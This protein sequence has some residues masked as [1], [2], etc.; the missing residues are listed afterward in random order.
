M[1]LLNGSSSKSVFAILRMG[2]IPLPAANAA[3][4]LVFASLASKIKRPLGS[5]TSKVSLALNF[6]LA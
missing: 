1:K 5:A 2:V 6:S 3:I 4:V